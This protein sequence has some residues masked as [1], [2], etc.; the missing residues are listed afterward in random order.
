MFTNEALKIRMRLVKEG[1]IYKKRRNL[2]EI[3]G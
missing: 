1:I 2:N 3:N